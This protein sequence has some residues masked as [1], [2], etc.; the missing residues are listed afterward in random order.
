MACENELQFYADNDQMAQCAAGKAIAEVKRIETSYSR[1]RDDSIISRINR[2]AGRSAVA[3]D[4]ETAALLRFADTCYR[5]SGGL[6]DITSGVLRRIWD[7][8]S[9]VVP[10]AQAIAATLPLI[11]W[12][13]VEFDGKHI[14]LTQ[15]GM[16]IDFGG[17]GKEYAADLAAQV[18]RANGIRSGLVN[19]GGDIC[20]LGPQ[21][22]GTPWAVHIIHPRRPGT[23][24]TTVHLTQGA[25]TTSGDYLRYFDI[26]NTRYCHIL[27]PKTGWPVQHW[28]SASVIAPQ[29][30]AAGSASTIAMLLGNAAVPFLDQQKTGYL[31]VDPQGRLHRKMRQGLTAP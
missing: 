13:K 6:F 2:E 25:L 8:R 10:S 18:L 22:D 11:G 12:D 20:I 30:S 28:Q 4:H 27:N 24:L 19:L 21:P 14:R 9:G 7:F 1:Y 16:E 31:L 5:A 26:G 15:A 29:C 23:L 17:I 3:L